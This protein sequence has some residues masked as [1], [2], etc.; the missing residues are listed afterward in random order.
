[1]TKPKTESYASG[2]DASAPSLDKGFGIACDDLELS[3]RDFVYPGGGKLSH[4][5]RRSGYRSGRV[6]RTAAF[7]H[8]NLACKPMVQSGTI[9]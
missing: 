9:S 7:E 2:W 8:V 6:G 1:M 4:Q 3:K 5:A